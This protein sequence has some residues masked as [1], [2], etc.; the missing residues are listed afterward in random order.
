MAANPIPHGGSLLLELLYFAGWRLQ[1]RNGKTTTV[2]AR[3]DGVEVEVTG[4][5]LEEAA[6]I[7]FARA[8]RSGDRDDRPEGG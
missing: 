3:R 5:N 2:R 4:A 6:G 7:A 8:M 1:V